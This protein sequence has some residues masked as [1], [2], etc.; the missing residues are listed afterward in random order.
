MI[1]QFFKKRF[2]TLLENEQGNVL[3]MVAMSMVML[4]GFTALVADGGSLFLEKSE[5]QK[6]LDAASLAGARELTGSESNA[7][8]AAIEVAG[9][10]NVTITAS[11]IKIG[12]NYIQISKTTTKDLTF[13]R[14]LGI[15]SADVPASAKAEIGGSLA[16]ARTIPVGIEQE[17]FKKG[18]AYQLNFDSKNKVNGNFGLLA[19]DGPGGKTV[20]DSIANGTDNPVTVPSTVPTKTGLTWGDMSKGIQYRMDE[21]QNMEKCSSYDTADGTCARVIYVPIVESY[22]FAHGKSNVNVVGIAAFWVKSIEKQAIVGQFI[23][24]VLPGD[25]TPVGDANDFGV[26]T[27]RLVQ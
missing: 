9:K 26:Y 21:D 22:A 1:I 3:V 2:Q 25:F 11:N 5:L 15:N 6:G 17:D 18:A 20:R 7:V 23:D 4:C 24:I 10:N 8:A 13:A 27:E 19:I 14:I 12:S 16:K